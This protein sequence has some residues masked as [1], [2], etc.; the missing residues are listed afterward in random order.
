MTEHMREYQ[1]EYFRTWF[2][3]YRAANKERV[4]ET[5]KRSR[6]R[7]AKRNFAAQSWMSDRRRELGYTQAELAALCGTT[8]ATIALLETGQR[9]LSTF[10]KRDK[11]LEILG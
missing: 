1:R 5:Q 6:K 10:C 8:Q 9:T 3:A 7:L 4:C 11:L 2:R